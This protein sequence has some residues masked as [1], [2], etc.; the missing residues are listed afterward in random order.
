MQLIRT[1]HETNIRQQH[2]DRAPLSLKQAELSILQKSNITLS[3][4]IILLDES[5]IRFMK[6]I[7]HIHV[8]DNN[9]ANLYM[10]KMYS[11]QYKYNHRTNGSQVNSYCMYSLEKQIDSRLHPLYHRKYQHRMQHVLC[12]HLPQ[13]LHLPML[14]QVSSSF[15]N[16]LERHT[17]HLSQIIDSFGSKGH[18]TLHLVL[19]Q[20]VHAKYT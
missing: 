4:K 7:M 18:S 15:D 16:Q 13:G 5:V 12:V 2:R 6:K 19:N 10:Y 3:L 14:F 17:P 8:A 9:A 11:Q 20:T 1:F